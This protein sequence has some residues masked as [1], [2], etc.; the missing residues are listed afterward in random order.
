M[1]HPAIECD[2]LADRHR[3]NVEGLEPHS[4]CT[5]RRASV[6]IVADPHYAST[7]AGQ[8]LLWMLTNLLARQFGLICRMEIGVP[9][10]PLIDGVGFFGR[11]ATLAETLLQVIAKVSSGH[12]E[13]GLPGRERPSFTVSAGDCANGPI[14]LAVYGA[15]WNAVIGR[16]AGFAVAAADA[17]PIGPYFAACVAAGE[18][19]KSLRGLLPGKG[20]FVRDLALCLWDWSPLT[21]P[22]AAPNAPP[23][24]GLSLPA[25]HIVG[26]GAVA[27]AA[28][29]V[30][31]SLRGVSG[32]ITVVDKTLIDAPNLNRY[33]LATRDDL[34]EAKV[35][36][37]S[38]RLRACGTSIRPAIASWQEYT[39][40]AKYR[41]DQHP[42]IRMLE[43]SYRYRH[44]LSCVDRNDAR[45]AIQNI[46][47]Q[48]LLG[49]STNG[50]SLAVADYDAL[51]PFECLKCHNP[52]ESPPAS[53]EA[54]A[55]ELRTLSRAERAKRAQIAGVDV[56]AME[57]YLADP[58]C[59]KLGEHELLK[60]GVAEPRD[61]SVGFVSVASGTMLAAQHVRRACLGHTIAQ[62]DRGNTL[63]YSFLSNILR[64]SKHRRNPHCDCSNGALRNYGS[65]WNS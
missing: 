22:V 48:H 9:S 54:I 7:A 36:V 49:A 28:C 14:D 34:N 1:I 4:A 52:I 11:R 18:V 51:T 45:H 3:G 42:D 61:W 56:Q 63:R 35:T 26:A 15:G 17:N 20:G 29:A 16:Q 64:W 62:E 43:E 21:S 58:G 6:R 39:L 5:A 44:V 25:T 55:A 12:I 57:R 50:L 31:G 46:W 40:D 27:Q 53:I 59:G 24:E 38:N 37:I 33:C 19:F 8:H 47:P 65:L 41:T 10:L 30:F 60:F 23:V 2:A 32:L 13:Y